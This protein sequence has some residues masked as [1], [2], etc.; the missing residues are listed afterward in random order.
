[1]CVAVCL[2]V[3]ALA[4]VCLLMFAGVCVLHRVF[5]VVASDAHRVLSRPRTCRFTVST[6]NW[7][8]GTP[9]A[10]T[11]HFFVDFTRSILV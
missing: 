3:C 5:V 4:G 6:I 1:M 11:A 10:R 8:R 2:C 9:L 7:L